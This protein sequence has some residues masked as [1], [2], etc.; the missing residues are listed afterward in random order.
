MSVYSALN[1]EDELIGTLDIWMP[2][3]NKCIPRKDKRPKSREKTA[4]DSTF[5]YLFFIYHLF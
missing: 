2:L 4:F 1:L 3:L 5:T